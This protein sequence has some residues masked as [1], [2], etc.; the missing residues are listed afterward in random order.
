MAETYHEQLKVDRYNLAD[1]LE[2]HQ[3]KYIDWSDLY[4]EAVKERDDLQEERDFKKGEAKD[5][6]EKVRALLDDEIRTNFKEHG[7]EKVSDKSVETWIIRQTSYQEALK[8]LRTVTHDYAVKVNTAEFKVNKLKGALTAFEHRKSSMDNLV[9]LHGQGYWSA[10]IPRDVQE[11]VDAQK[12][13]ETQEKLQT[14]L[15]QNRRLKRR[16][17]D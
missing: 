17:V 5:N 8:N 16:K 13:S 12:E 1:L 15:N 7:Y 2:T 14:A 11:E 6:L 4:A 3:D 10:R 9:K